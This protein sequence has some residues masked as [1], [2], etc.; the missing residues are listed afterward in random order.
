LGLEPAHRMNVVHLLDFGMSFLRL[1]QL[2][3]SILC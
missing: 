1:T 3:E 2:L